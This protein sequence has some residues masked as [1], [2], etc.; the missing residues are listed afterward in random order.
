M[1]RTLDEPA[2]HGRRFELCGPQAYTLAD[3]V[4]LAA[5]AAGHPRPVLPLPD[6]LARLQALAFEFLP[7]PTLLSRDNLDSLRVDSIA[8]RQPYVPDPLLGI[9][10]EPLEPRAREWLAPR[11]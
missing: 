7:G 9:G 1:C 2:A 8:S 5:A 3:L 11:H 10:P 6:A 4:R